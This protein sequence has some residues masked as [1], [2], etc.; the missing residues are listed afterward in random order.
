MAM[1]DIHVSAQVVPTRLQALSAVRWGIGG[2]QL[3]IKREDERDPV[4]GGNKWCKLRGHLLA[5]RHAGCTRLVSVGGPWSN[6]LLALAVAG[7][8]H[9]FATTGIVRGEARTTATLVDAAAAGMELHFV[10]RR[11]YR[12]RAEPDWLQALAPP[13][14][15]L[16]AEGGAGPE[17]DVGLAALAAELAGQTTGVV[18]LLLPVGS[19]TTFSGLVR[20]LPA[21]FSVTGVM[22]FHDPS[23]PARLTPGLRGARARWQLVAGVAARQ[24]ARLSPALLQLQADFNRHEGV[25]LDTVYGV[26]MLA[27]LSAC[28]TEDT[29]VMLHTGGLQGRRGHLAEVA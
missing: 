23:L 4:L 12:Q 13:G 28:A 2:R 7:A 6:H 24:H 26:R 20:H 10:S 18:Q 8:R 19:G 21:R 25:L 3:F 22:A 1:R 14:S 29:V 15:W 11:A 9:G 17:A 16:I 5:A 27:A